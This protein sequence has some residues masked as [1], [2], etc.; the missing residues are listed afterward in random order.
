M[1]KSLNCPE[2]QLV[3]TAVQNTDFSSCG[4]A[5]KAISTELSQVQG[6]LLRGNKIVIPV[7]LRDHVTRLAHEGHQGIVKTKQRLRSKVWWPR[8]DRQVEN[9]CRQ[10]IDCMTFAQPNP[11]SP[12]SMTKFPEKG[13]SY[14]SAD[15][16][17]PLPNGQSIIVMIDYYSRFF[18]CAFLNSTK[19]EKVIEFM[20]T[21]FSR[22]GYCDYLRT[23]NGLQFIA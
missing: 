14:L 8:M 7:S 11:P 2:I 17:G 19:S 4:T 23:D 18:E 21:V 5:Y 12:V 20:D 6:V 1:Q 22:F 15:L 3:I 9:Y 10:C 13:W 16:L